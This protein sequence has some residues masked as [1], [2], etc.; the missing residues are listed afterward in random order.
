V[1]QPRTSAREP[2]A[3]G[4]LVEEIHHQRISELRARGDV[5]VDE[6]GRLRLPPGVTAEGNWITLPKRG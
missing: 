5:G 3:S 4:D 2:A 6:N 1:K